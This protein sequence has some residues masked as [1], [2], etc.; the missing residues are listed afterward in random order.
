[1][2][3]IEAGKDLIHTVHHL[4]L[5]LAKQPL[6]TAFGASAFMA[7]LLMPCK[8]ALG[9]PSHT[10]QQSSVIVI[11]QNWHGHAHNIDAT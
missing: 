9:D 11:A 10:S 3:L 4:A 8:K 7:L 5:D 1:M 6:L 2:L